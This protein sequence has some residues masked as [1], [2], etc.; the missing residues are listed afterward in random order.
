MI[1]FPRLKLNLPIK[2]RTKFN[3]ED[4]YQK[5]ESSIL[6]IP[7][8]K[9]VINRR[10]FYKFTIF[11]LVLFA[12]FSGIIIVKYIITPGVT[13]AN[14][15]SEVKSNLKSL[16]ADFEKKNLANL[17]IYLKNIETNVYNISSELDTFDFLKTFETTKGYYDNFQ[18]LKATLEKSI[19]LIM[20]IYPDLKNILAISGFDTNIDKVVTESEHS[21]ED[22]S[23]FSLIMEELPLYLQIYERSL[24]QILEIIGLLNSVDTSYIPTLPGANLRDSFISASKILADFPETSAQLV[25]FAKNIPLIIGSESPVNYLVVLQNEAEMRASGGLLTAYG[26]MTLN[27]GDFGDSINFLDMWDLQFDLWKLAEYGFIWR[28]PHDNIYGQ[29]YL[30]NTGCGSTEA[31]AQ[32]VGLYPDLYESLFLFKPY[33]DLAL[34]YNGYLDNK[35]LAYQHMVIVNHAFAEK[36]LSLVQPLEV[37]GFGV[38]T[39]DSLFDFIKADS[40]NQSKYTG[41][42]PNRKQIVSKIAKEIKKKLF[43]LPIQKIPLVVSTLIDVFMAKDISFASTDSS[44][45]NFFDQY[46]LTAR[47]AKGYAGDYFQLNEAQNCSLKLN[48]FLRNNVTHQ[49]FIDSSGSINRGV[50]VHWEQPVVYNPAIA[51]QYSPTLQWAYRAWVRLIMPASSYGIISDGLARSN[52]LGYLWYNPVEYFDGL[53]DKQVSDNVIQFDHRRLNE[54]DPVAT[55]DL[56]ISY[57]LPG[58]INYNVQGE[59]TL[60]LQKHP[61]K[62]WGEKHTV[63][64]FYNDSVTSIE[65]VLDRDKLV[66]FKNGIIRVENYDKRLDWIMETVN[67]IPWDKI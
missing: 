22:T 51:F 47:T 13:I 61:G 9:G 26:V 17:D 67:K 34:E 41:F 14:Y 31:R 7:N 10:R 57:S 15:F 35:Y 63:N 2:K 65:T 66:T 58:S 8:T 11:F 12:L 46:G 28:M 3:L 4:S 30:M 21:E 54:W 40:D 43:D 19:T 39:A 32:D 1:R 64:I 49:V 38:V 6:R 62:S 60:I 56:N 55:Q 33:Y 48:K 23:T 24:P 59:Y 16:A 37:E 53:L 27:K 45:Q 18:I 20:E 42:D 25:E 36:L 50:N 5:E 29:T 52:T 44:M